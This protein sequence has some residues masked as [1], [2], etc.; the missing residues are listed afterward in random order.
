MNKTRLQSI[1]G[2]IADM[3]LAAEKLEILLTGKRVFS[4]LKDLGF[5]SE[6]D[7]ERQN[8]K[9]EDAKR[10]IRKAASRILNLAK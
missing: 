6:K 2:Q 4:G 9:I 8:K 7:L 1:Y 3:E 10:D 5:A